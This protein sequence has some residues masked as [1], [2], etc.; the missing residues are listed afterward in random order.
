MGW[1]G[2]WTGGWDWIVPGLRWAPFA[3][4]ALWLVLEGIMGALRPDLFHGMLAGLTAAGWLFGLG[5]PIP[6]LVIVLGLFPVLHHFI[7]IQPSARNAW[8]DAAGF[9]RVEGTLRDV[10]KEEPAE[11]GGGLG[12]LLGE[13]T[14][15][16]SGRTWELAELTV[17]LPRGS[18][19]RMPRRRRV[20]MGGSAGL[21]PDC[22]GTT[23]SRRLCL[24]FS[25]ADHHLRGQSLRAREG[26]SLRIRLRDRAAYYLSAEPLA[27]YLPIVLGLRERS[28]PEARGVAAVFRRVGIAHLFAISGLHVGLL[29]LLFAWL[30]RA[31]YRAGL[32][33]LPLGQGW[34][35]ASS[36]FRLAATALVWAYVAMIGFPVSAVRAALM[37][38]VLVWNGHWGV[39]AHPLLVLGFAALAILLPAP[40]QFYDLSFQMSFLAYFFLLCAL[41]TF[42]PTWARIR[43]RIRAPLAR[44]N[45]GRGEDPRPPDVPGAGEGMPGR[46]AMQDLG[47]GRRLT[48]RLLDGVAINLWLTAWITLGMWPLILTTFGRISLV[49]FIGNLVM[50]PVMSLLVLPLGVIALATSLALLDSAAGG[51]AEA[52]VFTVLETSLRGW[53]ALARFLDHLSEFLVITGQP[54][55]PSQAY[56]LYYTVVLGAVWAVVRPGRD[57]IGN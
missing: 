11:G 33:S 20:R 27:V 26:E 50:I 44:L 55:W 5:L 38:S 19:W 2:G 12:M 17:M 7:L 48:D 15:W 57:R 13:A 4:G 29:Y 49:V 1:I 22:S 28:T 35:H 46:G 21:D 30:P 42:G 43:A 23:A 40:S 51:M 32:G 3:L 10:W 31:L 9:T 16:R 6:A 56:L 37:G 8:E 53:I 18:P 24:R 54:H 52:L 47:R 39:R 41:G 34:V 36:V 25:Q 14:V 45:P